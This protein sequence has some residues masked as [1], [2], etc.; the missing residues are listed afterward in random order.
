MAG[1]MDL[2]G[3]SGPLGQEAAGGKEDP[4]IRVAGDK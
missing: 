1:T 2:S 4:E 3:T